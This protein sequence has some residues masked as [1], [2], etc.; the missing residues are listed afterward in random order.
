MNPYEKLRGIGIVKKRKIDNLGVESAVFAY[1]AD[2][3]TEERR[4]SSRLPVF[5]VQRFTKMQ[6]LV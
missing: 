3:E 2:V 4:E 6:K 1:K 5:R